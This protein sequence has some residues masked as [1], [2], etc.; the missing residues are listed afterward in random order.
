MATFEFPFTNNPTYFW[1]CIR[2]KVPCQIPDSVE[3]DEDLEDL[4]LGL[5]THYE[6]D[7]LSWSQFFSHP[8]VVDA[9]GEELIT[10]LNMEIEEEEFLYYDEG[11][12]LPD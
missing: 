10:S 9:V 11:T 4:I 5:V 3:I 12:I 8:F 2:K 6:K 7:R 1:K